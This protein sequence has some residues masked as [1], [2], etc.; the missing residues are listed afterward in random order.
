VSNIEST[1]YNSGSRHRAVR[2]RERAAELAGSVVG[3]QDLR[4]AVD[5]IEDRRGSR[6]RVGVGGGEYRDLHRRA[7]NVFVAERVRL[8]ALVQR[9]GHRRC[10]GGREQSDG[11]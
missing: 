8:H 3:A 7:E 11:K 2:R 9:D 5:A 10:G 4:V 1:R 6:L